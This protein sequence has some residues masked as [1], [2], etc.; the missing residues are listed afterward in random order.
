MGGEVLCYYHLSRAL[1]ADQPFYGLQAR[2]LRWEG[3]EPTLE[4]MAARYVEA[5]VE[6]LPR[7]P[8]LLGGYSFGSK[9]AFEMAHQLRRQGRRVALLALLDGG[10]PGKRAQLDTL[11]EG[12]VVAQAFREEARQKGEEFPVSLA[13]VLELE[14]DRRLEFVVGKARD[15]GFLPPEVG[16]EVVREYARGVRDR[17]RA[18]ERYVPEVYPGP[19]TYFRSTE[20]DEEF[21]SILETAGYD[22]SSATKG[23]E[24]FVA[25]PIEIHEVPGMHET[26]LV[27]PAVEDLAAALRASID[28]ALE[29]TGP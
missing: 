28:S 20:Q 26:L 7:G 1:G 29:A 22:V 16:V 6:A 13:S 4:E 11:D 14:P 18:S 2:G 5:V 23:W 8:Y 21:L 27:P 10:A 24:R 12:V 25:P 9:V 17:Q 15:H 19:V 3:T